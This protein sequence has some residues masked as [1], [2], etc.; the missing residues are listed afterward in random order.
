MRAFT[1]ILKSISVRFSLLFR[2]QKWLSL[3]INRKSAF[4]S[5][6][7]SLFGP[8]EFPPKEVQMWA[9]LE[10]PERDEKL[11]K[12]LRTPL[13]L[14]WTRRITGFLLSCLPLLFPLRQ[15]LLTNRPQH[16][17][18]VLLCFSP[19]CSN[20]VLSQF[21][22]RHG[23]LDLWP[24]LLCHCLLCLLWARRLLL[25]LLLGSITL[26]CPCWRGRGCL[27]GLFVHPCKELRVFRFRIASVDW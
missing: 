12:S 25:L 10:T 21:L 2:S 15:S 16:F 5:Y 6:V 24:P 26:S 7:Q 17:S 3:E 9:S 13:L 19:E 8:D 20:A 22:F 27:H 14:C 1:L 18:T 11:R 23:G 4:A